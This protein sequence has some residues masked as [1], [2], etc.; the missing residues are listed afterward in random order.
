MTLKAGVNPIPGFPIM[1][2]VT[3]VKGYKLNLPKN[4]KLGTY[5]FIVSGSDGNCVSDEVKINLSMNAIPVMNVSV[6]KREI[7]AGDSISLVSSGADVVRWSPVTGLDNPTSK[8]VVG[9]PEASTIY[10]CFGYQNG[11]VGYDTVKIVVNSI[12]KPSNCSPIS[13]VVDEKNIKTIFTELERKMIMV[14]LL[15]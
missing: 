13:L 5:G 12:P 14:H 8:T 6:D 1:N 9:K 7:S 10:T 4:L 3:F 11:C 2:D 15:F